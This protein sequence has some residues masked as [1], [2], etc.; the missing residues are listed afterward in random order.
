MAPKGA[1]LT[2]AEQARNRLA[3]AT[4]RGDPDEVIRQARQDLAEAILTDAIRTA[5]QY[6][7]AWPA[8]RPEQEARLTLLLRGES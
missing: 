6:V 4:R 1:P 8:F 5:R 7:A 2:E 3:A